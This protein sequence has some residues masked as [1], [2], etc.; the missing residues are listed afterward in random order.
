M[1]VSAPV[2]LLVFDARRGNTEGLDHDR[3]LGFYP[4][5]TPGDRQAGVAG[6]MQAMLAFAGDFSQVGGWKR[7]P[8]QS[9]L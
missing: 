1:A 6:L 3:L 9:C 2:Q 4:S 5:D 8:F 7:V